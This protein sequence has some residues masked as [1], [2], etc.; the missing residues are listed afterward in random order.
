VLST[1]TRP[2]FFFERKEKFRKQTK[3]KTR[4]IQV[5]ISSLA[6]SQSHTSTPD[7]P[8]DKQETRDFLDY[9]PGA[10]MS[11]RSF[12]AMID[13]LTP[14]FHCI[15]TTTPA[16]CPERTA[17]RVSLTRTNLFVCVREQV[18][19][20]DDEH[21]WMDGDGGDVRMEDWP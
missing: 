13:G 5:V 12:M 7:L 11:S 1:D 18:R 14:R 16:S 9:N 2:L 8:S 6:Q 15:I 21:I 3:K 4:P 19:G 17:S 10:Y 20:G